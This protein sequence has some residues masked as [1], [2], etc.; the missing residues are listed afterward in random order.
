MRFIEVSGEYVNADTI[1]SYYQDTNKRLHIQYSDGTETVVPPNR[2]AGVM[3]RLEGADCIIQVI[4]VAEPLYAV[5]EYEQPDTYCA[6]PVYYLALC[7]D[8]EIRG[9][10]CCEGW[11][12]CVSIECGNCVGL[13]HKTQL[14]RFPGIEIG[15]EAQ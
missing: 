9:V 14:E 3:A 13:Y 8:G 4:P 10:D 2:A 7:A 11:F 12:E 15:G 5:Y 1:K 6:E